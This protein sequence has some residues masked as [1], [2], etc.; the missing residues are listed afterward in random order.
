MRIVI[1]DDYPPVYRGTDELERL[2]SLGEVALWD[3]KAGSPDELR[4][5]LAGA[6]AAVNVRAYTRF[7]RPLLAALPDLRLIAVVG[8]GTDNVDLAAASEMGVVVSN[9]PAASAVSV[10]EF[11][12]ALLLAAARHIP[13]MD[14]RLRAGAWHPVEGVELR[15]RTLGVVGLGAI[16]QEVARL[17]NGLGM[18]V[19]A[20]SFRQD[21]QRAARVGARLVEWETLFRSAD[22]VS[23]HLRATPQSAGIVGARELGWLKPGAI[24]VNTARAALVDEG[25][26]REALRAGRLLAAGLDVFGEEPLPP[27][28]PWLGLDNAVLSPHVAW[29]TR[30]A[31]TRLRQMPVEN[32]EAYLAGAPRHVVNPDAFH[33][34]KHGRS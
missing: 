5:R 22:A 14:R 8:T 6:D 20:W 11:T 21:A 31:G 34:P 32:I 12:I 13:L 24:L 19:A 2:R 18:D 29:V 10:A 25:A 9:C 17:G 1:P 4:R 27:D 3:S 28:S 26:L 30:E 15:G 7:E 23:L 16:G 33:H